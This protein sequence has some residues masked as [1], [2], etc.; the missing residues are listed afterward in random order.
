MT[1]PD[2]GRSRHPGGG[3]RTP[4]HHG[5][6]APTEQRPLLRAVDTG[7][8]HE[9]Y[10]PI[11]NDEQAA[12]QVGRNGRQLVVGRDSPRLDS[13]LEGVRVTERAEL[14]RDRPANTLAR[15][16]LD[17]HPRRVVHRRPL[18]PVV[19]LSNSC[20]VGFRRGVV[21]VLVAR[22]TNGDRRAAVARMYGSQAAGGSVTPQSSTSG[23]RRTSV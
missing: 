12:V 21:E 13:T 15:D 4:E 7:R 23:S 10:Q 19:A 5:S 14:R 8:D 11:V 20:G 3:E 18:D 9:E 16:G 6:E 2:E 22:L 17:A 1:P